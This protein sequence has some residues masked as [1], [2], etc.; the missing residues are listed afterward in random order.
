IGVTPAWFRFP[1]ATFQ[2]WAPLSMI[3]RKAPEQAKNR[4]FRIFSA[5]ARLK[6]GVTLTQSQSEIRSFSERLA[7]EYPATNEGVT[8]EVQL[9]SEQLVQNA[10]PVLRVLLG[11]VLLLLLIACAN[12]ANLMLARATVREREMAIRAALGAG[13]ARLVRLMAIESLTLAAF[14]GVLGL[15]VAMW[16]VDLLP[17]V[18]EVRVP[19]ADGIRIDGAVLVFF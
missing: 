2:L 11:T 3:D 1:T 5:V 14:G 8:Y 6:P 15:L 18:L 10:R 4:A 7:R 16:G 9:L 19:R 12:V 17:S 13:R